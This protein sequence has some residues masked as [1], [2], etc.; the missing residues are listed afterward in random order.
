MLEITS[1]LTFQLNISKHKKHMILAHSCIAWRV[2]A[3]RYCHQRTH[4]LTHSIYLL[5]MLLQQYNFT[6][7]HDSGRVYVY[8]TP[9]S[10]FSTI[11]TQHT[12][13]MMMVTVIAVEMA[14]QAQ[15]CL[16]C[17]FLDSLRNSSVRESML[18]YRPNCLTW[19]PLVSDWLLAILHI[20]LMVAMV[21]WW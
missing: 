16:I 13:T 1:F 14:A 5:L 12:L 7:A 9:P 20:T 10:A 6:L 15:P 18:L 17:R 11:L 8:R 19:D 2:N 4:K 21:G 3:R